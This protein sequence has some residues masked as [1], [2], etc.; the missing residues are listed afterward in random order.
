MARLNRR[1]NPYD[2]VPD[3]TYRSG[4]STKEVEKEAKIQL[5]G[6]GVTVL[7]VAVALVGLVVWLWGLNILHWFTASWREST[8]FWSF[9]LP[10]LVVA[11]VGFYNWYKN[12][13]TYSHGS[14]YYSNKN[15]TKAAERKPRPV[16]SLILAGVALLIVGII[17]GVASFYNIARV[18]L[19]TST[20]TIESVAPS[21]AERAPYEVARLTANSSLQD[22]TGTAWATKSL[23][24]EGENGI[25]NTLILTRGPWNGYES[26]QTLNVPL[27]GAVENRDVVT[28]DFDKRNTLRHSGSLPHNNLSRAIFGQV[29]LNV[30]FDAGDSYGYCNEDGEPV[31]VTPLKQIDGWFSPTWSAYGVAVYNG[32]SGDLDIITDS[33]A[34][35]ELPGPTY[36]MSLATSQRNSLTADG[37]WIEYAITQ[38]AGYEAASSNTEVQLRLL[39]EDVTN[40]VTTLTPRGSSTSIVAVSSVEG[41]AVVSGERNMLTVHKLPQENIRAGNS[42]LLD[43]I[44]TRYSYLPEL[45]APSTKFFEVTAGV[46]GGWVV[47]IGRDQSVNYRAYVSATEE[48]TLIDRNGNV[49]AV[50]GGEPVAPTDPDAPITPPVAPGS[51]LTQLTDQELAELGKAV[52]DELSRRNL[53][54]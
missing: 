3:P 12:D 24:D 50:N 51:D 5:T 11:G 26:V 20:E 45:V 14:Y 9:V 35:A 48:I 47:S 21:Y 16:I 4:S 15:Q 17:M 39:D 36:P 37:T 32:I 52:I 40:Y 43:N 27:Y 34:I 42:T 53:L 29:P 22:T 2:R 7:L 18:Y 6:F 19:E 13:E 54:G 10:A 33:E 28:C 8:A 1:G 46:D 25:W 23:S 44:I 49:V 31:V 41:N 30:D 38:V